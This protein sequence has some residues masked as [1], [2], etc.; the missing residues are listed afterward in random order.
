LFLEVHLHDGS[1]QFLNPLHHQSF[2]RKYP[3]SADYP[4]AVVPRTPL[5]RV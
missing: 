3:V 1:Y 4:A 5:P 2:R